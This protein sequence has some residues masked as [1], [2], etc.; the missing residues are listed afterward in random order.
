[1]SIWSELFQPNEED[2]LANKKAGKIYVANFANGEGKYISTIFDDKTEPFDLSL[3]ISPRIEVRITYL[4][5]DEKIQGIQ[6]C[7]LIGKKIEKIN[8]STFGL[9]GILALLQIFTQLDLSSIANKSLI[10]DADIVRDEEALKKHLNTIL[11]DE[12]GFKV[13]SE[14]ACAKGIVPTDIGNL[15]KRKEALEMFKQLLNSALYFEDKKRAWE[16]SKDEDVWQHFFEENPWIFGYG[17]NFVF[18]EPLDDRKLEQVVRGA[19]VSGSGK[20]ADGI[21]KTR[22]L[23]SSLCLVEIKTGK[24]DLLK[25]VAKPYRADSWQIS[26]EI[27]GGIAQS[28]KTVQKTLEN[29]NLS[30]ILRPKDSDGNPTGETIFVYQPKSYLIVGNLQEFITEKGINNEKFSSFDLLR[31]NLSAPEIITFDELFERA[32]FIIHHNDPHSTL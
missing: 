18:N 24:T 27:A 28:Q 3:K 31:K 16:K 29:I 30:P 19:D 22:G 11:S 6:I 5:K 10:L 1:M 8:L 12:N 17:L 23:L 4:V 15:A 9:D 14:L 7:K 13:L 21:L 20:R 26:D 32:S 25:Q 2:I